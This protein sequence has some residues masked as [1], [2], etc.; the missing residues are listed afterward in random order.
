MKTKKITL[1]KIV[2][3]FLFPNKFQTLGCLFRH[4]KRIKYP[5]ICN[6]PSLFTL[7]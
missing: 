7:K 5:G 6:F 1:S 3:F 2:L 4:K